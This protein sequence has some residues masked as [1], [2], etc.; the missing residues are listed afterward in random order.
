MQRQYGGTHALSNLYQTHRIQSL[1]NL[2]HTYSRLKSDPRLTVKE[3]KR[4]C[5]ALSGALGQVGEEQKKRRQWR[6]FISAILHSM[7]EE[8]GFHSFVRALWIVT[9][10]SSILPRKKG[11]RRSEIGVNSSFDKG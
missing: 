2:I 8:P 7:A 1:K 9:G 5:R 6:A 3:H 4:V 10:L 11:Y